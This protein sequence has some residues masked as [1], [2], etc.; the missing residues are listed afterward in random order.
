MKEF[1]KKIW[2]KP[3]YLVI[4]A[5]LF[6]ILALVLKFLYPK[7]VPVQNSPEII[8]VPDSWE[9]SESDPEKPRISE[10]LRPDE[11]REAQAKIAAELERRK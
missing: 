6:G 10:P 11:I 8:G 7:D 5:F 4:P 2:E 9:K 1:F 3:W